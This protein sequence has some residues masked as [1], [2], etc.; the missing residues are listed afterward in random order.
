M[1]AREPQADAVT[2][3]ALYRDNAGDLFAYVMTLVRDRACAEDLTHTAFE[4]AY[5]RFERFD[6]RR[7]SPRAWLYGIARNAALDELRRRGRGARL[8]AEPPDPASIAG[9]DDE[10]GL[11]RRATVRVAL[12]ALDPHDRELVA[13]KFYAGLTNPEIGRVLGISASNAG[14]RLNR[15]VNR[16][17]EACNA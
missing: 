7:G 14:T 17:R 13:L 15:A 12:A 3:D 2:F 10:A 5:R 4:R 1:T 11:E 16:L 8:A 6:P 9:N